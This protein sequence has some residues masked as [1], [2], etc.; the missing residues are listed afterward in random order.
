MYKDNLDD[1]DRVVTLDELSLEVD[2]EYNNMSEEEK[3]CR[4]RDNDPTFLQYCYSLMG[5]SK[6]EKAV[7]N[8]YTYKFEKI[9]DVG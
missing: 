4:L 1:F 6:T 5:S 8:E 7:I 3:Y 2:E 9:M